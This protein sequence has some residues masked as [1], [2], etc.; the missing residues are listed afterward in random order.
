MEKG[1]GTY[2]RER[3][4]M[5]ETAKRKA[6][7]IIENAQ[8]KSEEIISELHKMKQSGASSIKENELIDARSRL[9]D[10][11]QPIMRKKNKVLQRAKKQ[12]EFHENDDVFVKTYGQRGVLTKRLGKHEW[13]VQ[14]GILKMKID[15][16]DL[17]KIKVE[18]NN[19]RGAGTVLKS[20]IGYDRS[21][22]RDWCFAPRNHQI[23]AAASYRQAF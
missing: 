20:S 23:S 22:Q 6:N 14:L 19:R 10:L 8:K 5:I 1:Y 3:D 21:W 11:E 16:D 9:N 4:N 12:Q 15:E 13:E 2:V 17:E 7:E 18:E